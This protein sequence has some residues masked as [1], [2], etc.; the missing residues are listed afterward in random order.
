MLCKA[1]RVTA[2]E[3]TKSK[4]G[5]IDFFVFNHDTSCQKI[6]GRILCKFCKFKK[7]VLESEKIGGSRVGRALFC[8]SFC[9]KH[10]FFWFCF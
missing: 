2:K 7:C 9:K 1:A 4:H 5:D 6:N 3:N 10:F 8:S